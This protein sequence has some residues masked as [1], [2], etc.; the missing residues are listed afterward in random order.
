MIIPTLTLV[1]ARGKGDPVLDLQAKPMLDAVKMLVYTHC[2]LTA[3]R[4]TNV[5][6]VVNT[7]LGK[8][9]YR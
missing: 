9:K 1:L 3:D 4:V 6:K 7:P 8:E 2:Q 5:H